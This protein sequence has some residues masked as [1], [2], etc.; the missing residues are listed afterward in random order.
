MKQEMKVAIL[1]K[2]LGFHVHNL[3][4]IIIISFAKPIIQSSFID[5]VYFEELWSKRHTQL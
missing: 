2:I 3:L 5:F 1:N 4:H